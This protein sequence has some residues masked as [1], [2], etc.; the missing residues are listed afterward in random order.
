MPTPITAAE[1]PPPAPPAADG[2]PPTSADG[3][4]A[5]GHAAVQRLIAEKSRKVTN[6]ACDNT[7]AQLVLTAAP[8]GKIQH[9]GKGVATSSSRFV[10]TYAERKMALVKLDEF[11][12][13]KPGVSMS[14]V[15]DE[16]DLPST[17]KP[18]VL[19]KWKRQK[20]EIFA[21]VECGYG[22]KCRLTEKQRNEIDCKIRRD[23]EKWRGDDGTLV[24]S[25]ERSEHQSLIVENDDEYSRDRME[26]E[27]PN[28]RSDIIHRSLL[29]AIEVR[30]TRTR[31]PTCNAGYA[32][33]IFTYKALLRGRD[34]RFSV[35]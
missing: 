31:A 35:L 26:E 25:N 17:I 7:E 6:I 12:E 21:A 18:D 24:G 14:M 32:R 19:W 2:P 16:M 15:V 11:H 10:P 8:G 34:T 23:E 13:K 20:Q 5:S 33:E 28:E 3:S 30:C 4:A 22:E 29:F 9:D 27:S 1:P